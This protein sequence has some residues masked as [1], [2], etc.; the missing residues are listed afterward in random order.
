MNIAEYEKAKRAVLS[1]ISDIV[2][3]VNHDHYYSGQ[4]MLVDDGDQ[5][6][7]DGVSYLAE[8]I[9]FAVKDDDLLQYLN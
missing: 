1:L 6:F 9:E 5:R 8:A 4:C 3:E 2:V 7:F